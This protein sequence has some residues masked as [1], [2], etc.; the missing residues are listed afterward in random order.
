MRL[1]DLEQHLSYVEENE[2]DEDDRVIEYIL[3]LFTRV[4]RWAY[5]HI[6]IHV[7]RFFN[8]RRKIGPLLVEYETAVIT[9]IMVYIV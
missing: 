8:I 1:S 2:T 9:D 3:K 5:Y 4:T 7:G 6:S